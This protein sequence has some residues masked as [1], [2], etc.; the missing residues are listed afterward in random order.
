VL[1]AA[2]DESAGAVPY[3]RS[4]PHHAPRRRGARHLGE[5]RTAEAAQVAALAAAPKALC[6]ILVR[7]RSI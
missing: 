5:E 3:A 7:N 6:A 4:T 2:E 1:P